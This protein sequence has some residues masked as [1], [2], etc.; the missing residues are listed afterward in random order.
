MIVTRNGRT[1]DVRND[2][3]TR[4]WGFWDKFA[5]GTWEPATFDVL[6]R[7]ANPD[8]DF[9]DIGAWVGPLTLWATAL[10]RAVVAVE[11]DPTAWPILRA[12]TAEYGNVLVHN[13]AAS[14][15]FGVATLY[16]GD[17]WGDSMSTL[18]P[19]GRP[20]QVVA[21]M[22][23]SWIVTEA[24]PALVKIDVEG[25]EASLVPDNVGLLH[26]LACPIILGLHWPWIDDQEPLRKAL[27][28]FSVEVLDD[29]RDFPTVVL[30]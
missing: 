3:Q 24:D 22:P 20:S 25:S 10:Y 17:A 9:L 27:D 8:R 6:D 28:T 18:H 4:S 29:H 2:P 21:T 13:A 7:Y 11:P 26:D 23:L 1:F 12:N 14:A 5:D 16:R 19:N 15:D 30:T